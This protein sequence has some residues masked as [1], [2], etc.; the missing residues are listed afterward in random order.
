MQH[1][2][3]IDVGGTFTDFVAHDPA[4][5]IEVWKVLSVPA[6]PVAGILDRA[7]AL[8]RRRRD[9]Q[10][11]ARHHGRDQRRARAQGCRRRLRHHQGL[12]GRAV[13]P[14]RQPQGPLRHELGQAQA[15]GQAPPLLRAGRAH[16]RLWCR[17]HPARPGRGA[18]R[19]R[20]DPGR[21]RDQGGRRL[22]AVLLPQP[23]PRAGG[24]GD[25]GR[26]AAGPAALDL[27]RG[28]AQVEGV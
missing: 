27:L 3:G 7:R 24:Q 21:A 6:D 8:S 18:R 26:G 14:A 12:Q 28:P 19:R 20:R 10:H 25:P 5:G 9:R 1:L 13:H 15:A 4:G 2:L 16:R 23:R 22:P 11:P 17:R